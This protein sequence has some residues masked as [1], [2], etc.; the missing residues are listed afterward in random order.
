MA[1]A[2][3]WLVLIVACGKPFSPAPHDPLPTLRRG[4]DRVLRAPRLVTVTWSGHEFQSDVEAFDDFL[5]G[6]RWLLA[7]AGQ[8]GVGAASNQN[9]R[10]EGPPPAA[11]DQDSTGAALAALIGEGA[12]PPPE[13]GTLYVLYF[14]AA[15][16][17]FDDGGTMAC[18]ANLRFARGVAAFGPGVPWVAVFDCFGELD[19]VT[20]NASQALADALVDPFLD[21]NSLAL[22]S[23]A[24]APVVEA[25]ADLCQG[26]T[27]VSEG[28]HKLARSWSDEAARAGEN[29]CEPVPA[30]EVYYGLSG[31]PAL[32]QPAAPGSTVTLD[33][34]GWSERE[35][36][37]WVL[38]PLPAPTDFDPQMTIDAPRIGNGGRVTATFTVPAGATPGQVGLAGIATEPYQG[39]FTVGVVVQ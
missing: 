5:P 6:S 30:G 18:E 17:F 13:D 21:S 14:S 32:V 7:V 35:V 38:V 22:P 11:L 2:T 8:Y 23:P 20:V 9:V 4:Q 15:T 33:L 36:D 29:P 12:V 1:R 24:A 34:T 31:S 19:D 3:C 25:P 26:R 16:W 10:L 39:T 28:K 27:A 37:S